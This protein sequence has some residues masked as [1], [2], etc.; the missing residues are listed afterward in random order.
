MWLVAAA[1]LPQLLVAYLHPTQQLVPTEAA[2]AALP[3]SLAVFLVFVW[4]NRGL[5]GMPILMI[6]L[7]LNLLVIAANGGWMPISPVTAGNL[8]GGSDP[9]QATLGTRFGQKDVLLLPEDTRLEFLSDRYLLPSWMHYATAFSLGDVFVAVGAFLL[10]AR[11]RA[12]PTSRV[13]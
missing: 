12:A 5:R 3:L 7:V 11:P 1:F 9:E 13:E 6:G 2:R 4:L 10:L 8:P